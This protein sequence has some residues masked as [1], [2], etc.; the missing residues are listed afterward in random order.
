MAAKKTKRK[1]TKKVLQPNPNQLSLSFT[2][3][4]NPIELRLPK[5]KINYESLSTR[6][7]SKAFITLSQF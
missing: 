7:S 5:P 6:S 3:S 1:V 4:E 2:E